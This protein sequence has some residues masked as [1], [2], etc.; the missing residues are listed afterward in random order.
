MCSVYNAFLA[1]PYVCALFEVLDLHPM[2][3]QDDML[4]DEIALSCCDLKEA[5]QHVAGLEAFLRNPI[6][7]LEIR[8]QT[9]SEMLKL[10]ANHVLIA[11]LHTIGL[12]NR[13]Y[14]L[15]D[16]LGYFVKEYEKRKGIVHVQVTTVMPLT[17]NDRE[18]LTQ[19][20]QEKLEKSV[21][22][23]PRINPKIL[24]GLILDIDSYRFD[25]SV[26]TKILAFQYTM[27]GRHL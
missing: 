9:L 5:L 2:C 7:S 10:D 14:Y 25:D 3:I 8:I 27:N 21:V 24:G 12:Y 4:C 11:W 18:S 23:E 1:R 6:I 19:H 16:I 15:S 17:Q 22:L 20:L 26:R 13:F